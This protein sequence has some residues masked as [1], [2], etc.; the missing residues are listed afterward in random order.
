MRT[1]PGCGASVRELE[2]LI[3][4]WWIWKIVESGRQTCSSLT[5]IRNCALFILDRQS[6]IKFDFTHTTI[7]LMATE[8]KCHYECGRDATLECANCKAKICDDIMCGQPTVDGYLCGF[9]TQ[10]GCGRKYTTCDMC[11]EERGQRSKNLK[12]DKTIANLLN[13]WKKYLW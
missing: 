2:V 10:W 8:T 1:R 3:L 11:L 7:V 13:R 5:R 9:Y 12:M 6:H 4:V